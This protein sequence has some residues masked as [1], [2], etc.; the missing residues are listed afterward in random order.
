M[1]TSTMTAGSVAL[2]IFLIVTQIVAVSLLPRTAGFTNLYWTIACLSTFAVS[3]WSLAY[4][5]QTGM[6]L[7]IVVPIVAAVVPLA[8]IAV[9]VVFYREAA[10]LLRIVLLCSACG[11][12][13]LAS[14]IK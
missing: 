2:F 7:S 9:G 12:I 4:I 1:D 10:S 5:I 6:P 14:V 13:G 8:S 11:V 3:Y